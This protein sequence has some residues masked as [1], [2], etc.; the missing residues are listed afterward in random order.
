[1][2]KHTPVEILP[3]GAQ[4]SYY[5]SLLALRRDNPRAWDVLSPATKFAALHYEG[6][7]REAAQLSQEQ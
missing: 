1:M 5:E 4:H 7:R 3:A 2:S 6:Q